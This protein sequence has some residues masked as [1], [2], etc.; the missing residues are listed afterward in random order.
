MQTHFKVLG[1]MGEI[2]SKNSITITYKNITVIFAQAF[3]SYGYCTHWKEYETHFLI[4]LVM[5]Y[6]QGKQLHHRGKTGSS[7][8][9]KLEVVVHKDYRQ[10]TLQFA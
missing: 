8:W 7:A 10:C 6:C 9:G 4:S 1:M 3:N 5:Q 2:T